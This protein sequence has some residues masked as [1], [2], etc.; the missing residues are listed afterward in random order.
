MVTVLALAY[1]SFCSTACIYVNANKDSFVVVVQF[2]H[3][4]HG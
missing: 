2:F 3:S 4:V 1:E